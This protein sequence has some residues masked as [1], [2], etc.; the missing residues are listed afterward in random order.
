MAKKVNNYIEL[1][2][3]WLEKKAEELKTYC[4]NNNIADLT[5]RMVA[6]KV[7]SKIEEQI[8][9]VRE[10]LQDYI[11]I[12]EAVDK[13]RNKEEDTKIAVRGG[14]ELSPLELGGI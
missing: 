2:L 12:I 5:D 1:E 14:K 9:C 10:T 11:K 7:V 13:L 8:K 4:D 6:G 3:K